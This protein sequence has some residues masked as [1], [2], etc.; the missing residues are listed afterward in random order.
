MKRA[1]IALYLSA[2]ATANLEVVNPKQLRDMFNDQSTAGFV[3][4][5]VSTFGSIP[6]TERD[7]IQII[8][9]PA[10]N[11]YGCRPLVRPGTLAASDKFVWLVKRGECTYSKKAFLAQQ[12]GAFAVLVYHNQ[13]DVNVDNIIPCAD[14]VCGL[15][16]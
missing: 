7:Y 15:T 6:Y 14:S 16:R 8:Q 4:Y 1:L 5:S 11:I 12:S 9:P 2:L 13:P 10:D 3:Q